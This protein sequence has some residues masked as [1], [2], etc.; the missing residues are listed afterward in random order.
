[1]TAQVP[2]A[3]PS[4]IFVAVSK[5]L[6]VRLEA[7]QTLRSHLLASAPFCAVAQHVVAANGALLARAWA[8]SS[9]C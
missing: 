5:L 8:I 9:S 4:L 6:S 2:H 3:H 1:M 7:A